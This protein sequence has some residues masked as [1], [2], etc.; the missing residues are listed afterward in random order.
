VFGATNPGTIAV[1]STWYYTSTGQIV[2]F[3]MKLNSYYRWGN[4]L[5][6]PNVMD[7]QNIV[8]HELGHG[9][10]MIDVYE[11]SCADVTM[12]GYGSI[13]ETKK[14]SLELADIE[15]LLSLYP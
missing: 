9:V 3:D 14:R 15:G 12:Y 13:G 6:T 2:E 7:L 5:V 11:N 4:S 1:T 10:G 8:T